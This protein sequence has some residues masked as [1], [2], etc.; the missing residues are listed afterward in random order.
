MSGGVTAG[1]FAAAAVALLVPPDPVARLSRAL[2]VRRSGPGVVPGPRSRWS[3]RRSAAGGRS[4]AG[5]PRR[6]PDRRPGSGTPVPVVTDLVAAALLTGLPPT[7]AVESVA[8]ALDAADDAAA[9]A[10]RSGEGGFEAL[11]EALGL[12]AATGLGPV[13]LVQAAAS[14]ARRARAARSTVAA[15]RLG[16]LVVLPTGLCLLPAFVLLTVAP[17]VL[18]LLLG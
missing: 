3:V 9:G 7:V 6:G 18:D 4:L 17:L 1:V 5:R 11:T 14:Q 12:A 8:D 10:L 16:T 15:R 13:P 2:G